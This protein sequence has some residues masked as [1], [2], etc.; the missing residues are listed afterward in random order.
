MGIPKKIF[1]YL[2]N[3]KESIKL[4][5]CMADD[6]ITPVSRYVDKPLALYGAGELGRMAYEY[7]MHIG[8][9]VV[10]IV[11]ANA[12]N[13]RQEKY[14]K[15]IDILKPDEVPASDRRSKLLTVCIANFP[16]SDIDDQLAAQGWK[17]IVPFYDIAES[18][19]HKHPLSN[20]WFAGFFSRKDVCE[21]EKTLARWEDDLSRAF[22]LQFIAWRRLRQEWIFTAASINTDN[23]FFIPELTSRLSTNEAF[24]DIGAHH[25]SVMQRFIENRQGHFRQIWA[26]EGDLQNLASLVSKQMALEPSIRQRIQA[27]HA[28]VANDATERKFHSGL[29]YASQCASQG[30]PVHCRT[31]DDLDITPTFIKLHIEGMELEALRGALQTIKK[32]RPLIAVTVYH[33]SDG[34]W[35][36]PLWLQENLKDYKLMLRMHSWCG[37]GAVLYALPHK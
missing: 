33:N 29:G 27:I 3:L 4:L 20:G 16:Y 30:Q 31:I 5:R 25:G 22:H 21:I 17:D 26:I 8:I 6:P 1:S 10:M 19:R 15:G 23:R 7:F 9:P 35:K 36:I 24:A 34:L 14:W 28:V 11:D 12:E 37:T 18:Y 13:R 32:N 2:P